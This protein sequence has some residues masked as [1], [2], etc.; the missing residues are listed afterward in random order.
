MSEES[1][2]PLS[3][4]PA[5]P[6]LIFKV[7]LVLALVFVAILSFPAFFM[8]GR[9]GLMGAVALGWWRFLR[10]TLPNISWNWDIVGMSALCVLLILVIAHVFL[11]WMTKNIASARGRNWCW[12]WKWT[13]CG[14]VAIALCFVVGMCVGG[15]T[16]QVGWLSLQSESWYERKGEDFLDMRQLDGALQRAL[17]ETNGDVEKARQALRNPESG[18]FYRRS[19]ESPLIER[20]HLLLI[21]DST[22][23]VAGTIIFPRDAA[24]RDHSQGMYW[25]EDENDYFQMEKLPELVEKHQKQLLAL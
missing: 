13:W 15:V 25:F 3:R 16:H 2:P 14:L 18:Y 1:D 19:G 20:F 10:R 21:M 11:R 8:A 5:K 23:K 4:Q 12:P 9:V 24:R 7:A 22:N 17:L 6:R